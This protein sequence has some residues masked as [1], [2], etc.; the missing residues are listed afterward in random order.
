[1]KKNLR[2]KNW[3]SNCP[4]CPNGPQDFSFSKNESIDVSVAKDLAVVLTHHAF[5]Q[6]FGWAYSTNREISC[7]GSI[8]RDGNIFI[9]EQL[10]LLKQTGSS[11]S[12]EIDEIAIAELIEKLLAE[13]KT[14]GGSQHQM[15]GAQPSWDGGIL[16]GNG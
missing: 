15:L 14:S 16:V 9:V 10:H 7:L 2:K 5:E 6:L 8:R 11:V 13:G 1:M 3:Q 12:T 4:K